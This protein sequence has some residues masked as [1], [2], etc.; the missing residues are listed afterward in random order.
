MMQGDQY[1]MPIYLYHEDGSPLDISEVNEVE[2]F[3]GDVGH[4]MKDGGV[5]YSDGIFYFFISQKESM[6]L[7][8]DI[9]AQ[10]RVVFKSG[11]VVGVPLG[12]KNVQKSVSKAVLS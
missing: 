12:E 1:R 6:R 4:T 7:R 11:D 9:H 10:A 8:G 3:I 5:Q 2:I